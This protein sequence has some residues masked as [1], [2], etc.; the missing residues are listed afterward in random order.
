MAELND[1]QREIVNALAVELGKRLAGGRH[2][3]EAR[4]HRFYRDVHSAA[5]GRELD[6]ERT[7]HLV[8][9]RARK[10]A[11]ET[12]YSFWDAADGLLHQLRLGENIEGA[13]CERESGPGKED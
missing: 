10:I 2:D 1:R 5:I 6:P 12:P 13:T 11:R 9:E 8:L 3:D 4:L 7:T